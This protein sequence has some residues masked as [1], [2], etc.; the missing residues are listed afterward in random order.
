[1]EI[2]TELDVKGLVYLNIEEAEQELNK[3]VKL[4]VPNKTIIYK[5][6]RGSTPDPLNEEEVKELMKLPR[7]ICIKCLM[8]VGGFNKE[9]S[10]FLIK[11]YESQNSYLHDASGS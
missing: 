11:T 8:L 7:P 4:I 1:M 3:L 9:Q 2:R 6:D 5:V 10:E